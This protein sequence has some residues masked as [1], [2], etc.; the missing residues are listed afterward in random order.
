MS[1]F[2][3]QSSAP[4]PGIPDVPG[5]PDGPR[6]QDQLAALAESEAGIAAWVWQIAV[7]AGLHE[8]K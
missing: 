8:F 6:I 2:V 7:F 4:R 1:G 3:A 5:L